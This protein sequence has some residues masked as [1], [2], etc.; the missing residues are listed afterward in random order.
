[1]FNPGLVRFEYQGRAFGDLHV[2]R[3]SYEDVETGW[4]FTRDHCFIP[5]SLD[6][7]EISERSKEFLIRVAEQ[8]YLKRFRNECVYPDTPEHRAYDLADQEE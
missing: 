1:M 6:A 5:E 3:V 4:R 8:A 7:P 2:A